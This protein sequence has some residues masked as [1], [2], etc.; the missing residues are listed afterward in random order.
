MKV[1]ESPITVYPG[2]LMSPNEVR[3]AVHAR[4]SALPKA[5]QHGWYLCG[6]VTEELFHLIRGGERMTESLDYFRVTG[7]QLFAVFTLQVREQ[8]TRF[9]LPLACE[10]SLRF[11]EQVERTGVFM[12]LGKGGATDA[13]LVE[14]KGGRVRLRELQLASKRCAGLPCDLDPVILRLA[15]F[16]MMQIGAIPS[17]NPQFPVGEVCLTV[18]LNN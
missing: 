10:K 14:F 15:S 4:G 3:S 16:S 8:Q 13:L 2:R 9:L 11:I 12:S 7:G 18:I 5:Y 1:A 17:T 6:D